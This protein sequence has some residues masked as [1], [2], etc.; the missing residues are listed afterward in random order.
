[1]FEIKYRIIENIGM[2]KEWDASTFDE[3]GDVEGFFQLNFNGNYY[4]YY[5]N[6]ELKNGE[7]GFDLITHWFEMLIKVYLVLKTSKY[8]V[9]SDIESFNTWLEFKL[10]SKKDLE[11]S[12]I[13]YDK[14]DEVDAI[15]TS[16]F[17][18]YTFSDWKNISISVKDFKEEI[19]KQ[20]NL[21][22]EELNNINPKLLE[23]KR[24]S[25]LKSLIYKING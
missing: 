13:E 1:M 24:I 7:T 23:S 12:I 18:K 3:E 17:D 9:L 6:R 20:S 5:H 19:F 21:Y 2:L 15:V 8:V 25:N 16:Q 10:R 22:V 14:K 11:V 4:G